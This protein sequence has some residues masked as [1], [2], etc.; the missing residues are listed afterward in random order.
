MLHTQA[1]GPVPNSAAN[2][3]PDC[4]NSA[5]GRLGQ[6]AP[7]TLISRKFSALRGGFLTARSILS[8]L[9]GRWRTA[10]RPAMGL[11]VPDRASV[12]RGERPAEASQW[13]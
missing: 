1:K 9:T 8:L 12:G 6:I 4:A 5:A 10:P 11:V 7:K 2:P 13:I 3:L